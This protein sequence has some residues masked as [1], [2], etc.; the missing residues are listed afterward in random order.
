MSDHDAAHDPIDKVYAQA[1]AMLDDDAARAARRAR[2][3]GAVAGEAGAAPIMSAPPKRRVS[4]A[5]GRW[6][7]AAG[8]AGVGVLLAV[9][10]STRR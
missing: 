8:V 6:L 10:L 9:Q 2:V 5:A 7:A 4:W 3:L 1:E